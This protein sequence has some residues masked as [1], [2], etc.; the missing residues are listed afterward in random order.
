[1]TTGVTPRRRRSFPA[2]TFL[3]GLVLLLWGIMLLRLW[4]TNRIQIL[5]HPNYHP[6]VIGAGIVLLVMGL[7]QLGILVQRLMAGQAPPRQSHST[8]FPR[9]FSMSVLLVAALMGLLIPPRAFSSQTALDRAGE[10][11]AA[12]TRA[13]PQSFQ[14]SQRP[15]A[16][17]IIDWIR[18]LDVYPEPDAYA[19]QPAK[20][21]G[22]AMHLP[23]HPDNYLTIARFVI[24]CCAADAY[25][26]GLPVKL[27]SSRTAYPPDTWLA[28]EGEMITETLANR[29][30]LVIQAKS[31]KPIPEPANPYDY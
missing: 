4:W 10:N 15:E 1:M 16:R 21:Q 11:F 26:V 9:N 5:I 14:A 8:L 31:L 18:T 17:S 23:Q 28:V 2:A 24:T 13:R 20:V 25:P 6:L 7:G 3:D 12:L 27:A 19:G 29:R 30:Q 22:F